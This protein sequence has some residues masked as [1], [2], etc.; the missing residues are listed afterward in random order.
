MYR[1][2]DQ[3]QF[4]PRYRIKGVLTAA[5][6]LHIGDG[7]TA[8]DR[9]PKRKEKKTNIEYVV[10]YST[11][12]TDHQG[13]PYIPASTLKGAINA[14][15]KNFKLDNPALRELLGEEKEG[16]PVSGG[17]LL[18]RN[19]LLKTGS[20]PGEGRQHWSE[21]R[22]TCIEPHVVI[23]PRTGTAAEHLLYHI[24]F[25]PE[26]TTFAFECD[27]LSGSDEDVKLVLR[28]LDTLG[29]SGDLLDLGSGTGNDWGRLGWKLSS[30]E[31]TP[32]EQ[33]E[34]WIKNGAATPLPLTRPPE[35]QGG[36]AAAAR[37]AF[38]GSSGS[39]ALTISFTL[40]FQG[41]LII[42][43]PT[44]EKTKVPKPVSHAHVLNND[45][46]NAFPEKSFRGPFRA[47]MA[48][49][50]RTLEQNRPPDLSADP[51][52]EAKGN[53]DPKKLHPF[54]K[55]AGAPGWKSPISFR[56]L[57]LEGGE[58]FRQEMV[59]I[60]RFTGGGADEKKFAAEGVYQPKLT[61]K[62]VLDWKRL[63][64]AGAG[65]W[66]ALLLLWTLRDLVEGDIRFGHGKNKGFGHCTGSINV[67]GVPAPWEA[68]FAAFPFGKP[69]DETLVTVLEA[70]QTQIHEQVK[71][72]RLPDQIITGQR[73]A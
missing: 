10:E 17:R 51:L 71:Q 73:G 43:D 38:P 14:R 7:G 68:A 64:Y 15:L 50:W 46:S 70:W 55:L 5:T 56:D 35:P 49:I 61:G 32:A 52:F 63:E 72:G 13:K 41:G 48:R 67:S 54:L 58:K 45:G 66:I 22:C 1:E 60:D 27:I 11:V 57:T 69:L 59:A 31:Y 26:R 24:E 19:A 21:T 44:Q 2:P 16:E 18:F 9:L 53:D 37:A 3:L 40:N 30:V 65:D 6:K 34:K 36:W 23:D 12:C 20:E 8:T 29:D 28:G 47:Q 25:V 33:I 62:I 4:K 39:S 42:H